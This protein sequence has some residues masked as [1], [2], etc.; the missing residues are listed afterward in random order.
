MEGSMREKA[1]L[2]AIPLL[3]IAINAQEREPLATDI[4]KRAITILKIP[5]YVDFLVADGKAVWATNEGRIEKLEHDRSQPTA[6]V[7]IPAPCGAMALG[8]GA[9][10]VANCGDN[11]LYRIDCDSERV[12]SIIPTGL[13]DSAGE[14]SV[15]VGAGSIWVLSDSK[16][17]LSR[18]DPQADKVIARINVAPNSYAATFGFDSVWISNTG[19]QTGDGKGYIQRIDPRSNQ[20]AA[21]IPV[22]PSP[23]FLAAGEGG[24]WTL[25]QGDG[26]VSR[27]DPDTN[28]LTATIQAGVNGP[29]GDIAA[30]AG[31]IWVR[32]KQI[33][34]LRIDPKT[35]RVVEKFGPPA[36][37]GAVRVADG[38]VWITAHDIQTVW[39]LRP[40]NI[41]Y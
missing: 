13:A 41:G 10:W 33:L 5:G 7:T 9:V 31:S 28:T 17:I 35:N 23:R 18:V 6:V 11:S 40:G 30:G 38:L 22:G 27:I 12:T 14:L 20:V 2:L 36:G 15:A 3:F 29:G 19:S 16:G 26:S 24:V 25:N 39:V 21:T 32:G 8:F 34:L 4:S 37:S 1:K